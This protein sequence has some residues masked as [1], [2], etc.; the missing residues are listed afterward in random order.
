MRAQSV[1]KSPFGFSAPWSQ[2]PRGTWLLTNGVNVT[3]WK[4]SGGANPGSRDAVIF[5]SPG[6]QR[7]L[8]LRTS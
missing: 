4:G 1:C 3:K 7:F 2:L 5:G 6:R 8:C